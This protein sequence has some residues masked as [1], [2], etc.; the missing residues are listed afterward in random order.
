M[1][2]IFICR[3]RQV[4]FSSFVYDI[5]F[6][7]VLTLP[8]SDSVGDIRSTPG[9]GCRPADGQRWSSHPAV[10]SIT[11]VFMHH[12]FDSRRVFS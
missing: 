2:L 12:W 5:S 3:I 11:Q 4:A 1:R 6:A 7:W 8:V 9:I 10:G